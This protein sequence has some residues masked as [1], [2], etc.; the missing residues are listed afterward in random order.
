MPRLSVSLS[1]E[2]AQALLELVENQLFRMK[3]IDTK[4]PGYKADP[5]KLRVSTSAV[6][7]VREVVKEAKGFKEKGAA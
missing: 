4:M 7:A 6:A 5:E 2:E 1:L 3:F